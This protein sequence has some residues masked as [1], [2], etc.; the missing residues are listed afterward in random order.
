M[1]SIRERFEAE[2]PSHFF[3]S[4]DIDQ[5]EAYLIEQ[6]IMPRKR[7]MKKGATIDRIETLSI[8]EMDYVVRVHFGEGLQPHGPRVI[9]KQARPW[10]EQHSSIVAPVSR[11]RAEAG[12]LK[13]VSRVPEL[14]EA[15][16]KL[17]HQD[18]GNHVMVVHDF[19]EGNDLSGLYKGESLAREVNGGEDLLTALVG[20]LNTLH[21]HFVLNPPVRPVVNKGMRKLNHEQMFVLPFQGSSA[22]AKTLDP[23]IQKRV[24]ELGERYLDMKAGGTLLHGDFSPGSF[25]I[26]TDERKSLLVIDPES[27]FSGPPEFDFGVF[28]AHLYLSGN[29][30][31]VERAKE[32]YS[33]KLDEQ[34]WKGYAGVEMIRSL[35]GAVQIPLKEE[36]SESFLTTAKRLIHS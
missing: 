34:L 4:E 6:R 17:I 5:V 25:R 9:L 10:I 33:G 15:S 7:L 21:A 24:A 28:A 1:S 19:D 31:E 18:P 36:N 13:M 14:V 8:G 2:M 23:S 11:S 29:E 30:S 20:Y 12:F 16:P 3:L 26:A 35:F 32:L 27:C 22:F